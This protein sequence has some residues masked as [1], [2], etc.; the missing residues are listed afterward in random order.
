MATA[1]NISHDT[2]APENL[3]S[4][5]KRY[6]MLPQLLGEQIIDKAI[7]PIRCSP[8]ETAQCCQEWYVH[9]GVLNES[10]QQHW[11]KHQNM[12]VE[13]AEELATRCLRVEKFKHLTWETKLESYFLS[14]KAQL[15]RVIYSLIRVPDLG[16]AQELYFRLE[17]GEYSF[18]ELARSY[19]QGP[20][21][22][23]GGVIGPV[24]LGTLQPK[25][26]QCLMLQ[27]IGRASVP[28]PWDSEVLILRL[29]HW[30]PAQLN[31]TLRQRLLD[32]LFQTWLKE[33][34]SQQAL[35]FS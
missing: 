18:V 7:A 15:D 29:E 17:E 12:S 26:A 28:I 32:E 9:N 35:S 1:L 34:M 33:Q 6:Q 2:I 10:D 5:L 22:Q 16:V 25:L 27:P 21:A 13:E 4:L 3:L 8:A 14:R 24:E 11:R 30:L 31:E 19:S 20:E 23:T